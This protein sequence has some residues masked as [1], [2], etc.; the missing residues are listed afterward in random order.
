MDVMRYKV[1]RSEY[2]EEEMMRGKARRSEHG[3]TRHPHAVDELGLVVVVRQRHDDVVA[4]RKTHAEARSVAA[5]LLRRAAEG[6][7]KS[8]RSVARSSRAETYD[9]VQREQRGEKMAHEGEE[10]QRNEHVVRHERHRG[11]TKEACR[12]SPHVVVGG[13]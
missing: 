9:R 6:E 12:H 11:G 2:A 1:R 7:L 13:A 5:Q 10:A 3:H 4:L 8:E